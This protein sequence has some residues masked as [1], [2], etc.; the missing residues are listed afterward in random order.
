MISASS[1]VALPDLGFGKMFSRL[2]APAGAARGGRAEKAADRADAGSDKASQTDKS[3]SSDATERTGKTD[4]TKLA[5]SDQAKVD[6]L[7]QID[8]RVRAH[9]RAH[10][11]AGGG[12]V[13]G[14]ANFSYVRGPD[15]KNYAV[16]GEVPI[17]AAPGRT[18]EETLDKAR[19]IERAALAPAD[20][21]PQDR[22]VAA[23]AQRLATE[24]SLELAQQRRETAD[25]GVRSP[26]DLYRRVAEDDGGASVLSLLA[27]A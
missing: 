20:P 27:I 18:P 19:T 21:S 12:L 23:L 13:R 17:D 14:G 3:G 10:I 26:A 24:A 6:Q 5:A 8:R 22:R 25:A 1:S 7:Q 11:A 2:Q 4:A 9:E 15:G 16:G